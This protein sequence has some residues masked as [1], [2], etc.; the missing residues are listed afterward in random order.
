MAVKSDFGN[1]ILVTN[2]NGVTFDL[3]KNYQAAINNATSAEEKAQLEREREAKIASKAYGGTQTDSSGNSRY[4]DSSYGTS[5]DSGNTATTRTS[6]TQAMTTSTGQSIDPNTGTYYDPNGLAAANA[7]AA[8]I[9]GVSSVHDKR[10]IKDPADLARI[11]QLSALAKEAAASGNPNP[12]FHQEAEAIRAKYYY[13]GGDMGDEYIPLKKPA[14]VPK[15]QYA[16]YYDPSGMKSYLDQWLSAAQQQQTN[17]IDYATQ[18]AINELL[19]TQKD[20]EATFQEQRDQ[21]E[22]EAAK[23]KDN[24]ALY[25]ERRGDRGGIGAAQYDYIS[26][27]AAQNH[28]AVNQAQ[29]KLA[30][31]TARQISDLRAQGEYEKADALLSLSQQYLSQLMAL[32]QW[33]AEYNLSVQQFN[34]SLDQWQAEFDM[35]AAEITGYYNGQPTIQYQQYQNQNLASAGETLLAAGIMPSASQL[36]AMNMTSDQAQSYI[37]ALKLAQQSGGPTP[38]APVVMTDVYRELYDVGATTYEE[39]LAYLTQPNG[40][41]YKQD[42]LAREIAVAYVAKYKADEFRSIAEKTAAANGTSMDR[43]DF[44]DGNGNRRILN[45]YAERDG[46]PKYFVSGI[47][48]LNEQEIIDGLYGNQLDFIFDSEN[49]NK[50]TIVGAVTR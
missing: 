30:T 49:K 4:M 22:V 6:T 25:A 1:Q 12:A 14:E 48:W 33:S 38:D 35:K 27:T 46:E 34:A 28:L 43:L 15:A 11:E 32:E 5:Y 3:N 8:P 26:A 50:F 41:Y 21:I 24:Q 13:S 23:V 9:V 29:T 31:D 44:T 7:K 37:T 10:E 16:E 17:K 20:A 36:A 2:S 18:Q 47:G 45:Q 42:D 39:A 40:L 19:R